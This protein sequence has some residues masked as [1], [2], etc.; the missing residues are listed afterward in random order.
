MTPIPA[1]E[2]DLDLLQNKV[3]SLTGELLNVYEELTLL[4]SLAA[5][6]GPL[7]D[8]DEI[9]AVALREA[10]EV[11]SANCGWVV[12]WDEGV[13]RIPLRCCVAI[14]PELADRMSREVLAPH[15]Q[16]GRQQLLVHNLESEYPLIEGAGL[17]GRLLASSLSLTGG[18]AGYL[19][20][21]RDCEARMFTSPDQKLLIAIAS[22]TAM[23]LE[24]LRL[25]RSEL[26][27]RRLL[28]EMEMA[29]RIQSL[30]LPRDF[31]CVSFLDAAGLSK[32]CYEIGGDYYDLLPTEDGRCLVVIADVTGKGAPASLQAALI[33]GV[34]H[35]ASHHAA[36]LSV[37]MNTLNRCMMERAVEGWYP[38]ALVASLDSGGRL[39]YTNA[40]HPHPL[41]IRT[42]GQVT[43]LREGGP[44]LG[45]LR[46]MNY[47]VASTQMRH[48]DLLVMYTDGVTDA[49]NDRKDA[50]GRDR[51]YK[52]A[53]RQAG[54]SPDSV[55]TSL[56]RTVDEFCGG[57]CQ[58]DD[59]TALVVRCTAPRQG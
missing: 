42:N 22:L 20:L 50:F 2:R 28:Q 14:A 27:K 11:L 36:E 3:R 17:P 34:I 44:L 21:G 1:T 58:I 48:G 19:C 41:L 40:G 37:L 39:E 46:G 55:R 59:L 29:R 23:E 54:H 33:Q 7:S 52:W 38:T 26:E 51:L 31:A 9:P 6:I 43:L 13:A 4:Y 35:G 32:P 53:E 16:Q 45:F 25:Q 8:Q 10:I 57:C 15:H 12:L 5:E 18:Q 56:I 30:L 47:P 49:E 24:N